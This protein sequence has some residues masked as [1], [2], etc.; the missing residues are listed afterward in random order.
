VRTSRTGHVT[1]PVGC[2]HGRRH[3]TYALLCLTLLTA[4]SR[5]PEPVPV[6]VPPPAHIRNLDANALG[7]TSYGLLFDDSAWVQLHDGRFVRDSGT[8]LIVTMHP[9]HAF[10]DLDE[11]GVDDAVVVL[12]VDGGGSGTFYE[13]AAVLDQDGVAKHV[14][15]V[16]LGDRIDLETLEIIDGDIVLRF[17][18]HAPGDPA[19]CPTEQRV[20]AFAL[21]EDGLVDITRPDEG[22]Q[23]AL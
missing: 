23:P 10:G 6:A 2:R 7:E 18:G 19:C 17:R 16:T 3:P 5:D 14:A 13:L 8:P 20:R 12:L 21:G 11:D 15:S 22:Q 9:R 4:C 1:H